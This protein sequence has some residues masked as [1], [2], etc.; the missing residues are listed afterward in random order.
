MGMNLKG[1]VPKAAPSHG[2]KSELAD[3]LVWGHR[4]QNLAGKGPGSHPSH[5][6]SVGAERGLWDGQGVKGELGM[7]ECPFLSSFSSSEHVKDEVSTL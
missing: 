3:P 5:P 4:S 1:L 2:S 6:H 7:R